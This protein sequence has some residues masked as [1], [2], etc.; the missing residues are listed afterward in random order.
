M[1][2]YER[3]KDLVKKSDNTGPEAFEPADPRYSNRRPPTTIR[4]LYLPG[5]DNEECW[6]EI[7]SALKFEFEGKVKKYFG[8]TEDLAGFQLRSRTLGLEFRK[9]EGNKKGR[10]FVIVGNEGYMDRLNEIK[11]I[12]QK[13]YKN[14][15]FSDEFDN[16]LNR[17]GFYWTGVKK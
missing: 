9:I 4:E 8:I 1:T 17:A 16:K 11:E 15:K 3:L 14:L 2:F 10:G 5:E 12:Y 6:C 13:S 7:S